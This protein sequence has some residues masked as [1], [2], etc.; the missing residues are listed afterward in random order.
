DVWRGQAEH[1]ADSLTKGDRVMITG[2]LRQRTWETPEGGSGRWP[3]ARPMRAGPAS[4]GPRP[5]SSARVNAAAATAAKAGTDRPNAATSTRRHRLIESGVG[6]LGCSRRVPGC[7]QAAPLTPLPPS[8]WLEN[9]CAVLPA[10]DR[11]W[12]H[13]GLQ[14]PKSACPP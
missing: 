12:L 7:R 10:P 11:E 3:R 6:A 5:R 13:R 9:G 1:L 4:S 8:G 14:S 2:R